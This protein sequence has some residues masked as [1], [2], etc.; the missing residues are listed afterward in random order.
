M[1]IEPNGRA[2]YRTINFF[3]VHGLLLPTFKGAAKFCVLQA[4][5]NSYLQ[6]K[7]KRKSTTTHFYKIA[8]SV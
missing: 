6:E 8:G 7:Q 3:A 1:I 4:L 5:T 2:D